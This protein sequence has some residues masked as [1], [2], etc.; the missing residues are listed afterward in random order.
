MCGSG[1]WRTLGLLRQGGRDNGRP[2]IE[3]TLVDA[4][5]RYGRPGEFDED[6]RGAGCL[7]AFDLA[8]VTRP[9]QHGVIPVIRE[10]T[11]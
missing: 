5:R 1:H 4:G 10:N 3:Y 7:A 9:T 2:A 6:P 11:E 8:V